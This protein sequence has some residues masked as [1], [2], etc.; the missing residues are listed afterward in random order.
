VAKGRCEGFQLTAVFKDVY[1]L[2]YR[3][4]HLCESVGITCGKLVNPE[5][6]IGKMVKLRVV[7]DESTYM[8]RRYMDHKIIR[9]HPVDHKKKKSQKERPNKKAF[10]KN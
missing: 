6:L 1:Q 10:T 9:F 3:L 8:G 4:S 7:P 2:N 5:Y